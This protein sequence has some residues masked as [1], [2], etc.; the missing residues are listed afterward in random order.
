MKNNKQKLICAFLLQKFF[1]YVC[2]CMLFKRSSITD[3]HTNRDMAVKKITLKSWT[4]RIPK[5]M[6][7]VQQMRT[8]LPMGFKEDN[9]VCTTSFRPGARFITLEFNHFS[10][11]FAVSIVSNTDNKPIYSLNIVVKF[12]EVRF[13]KGYQSPTGLYFSQRLEISLYKNL[14]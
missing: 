11:S 8:M 9:R 12:F 10:V 6:K 1:Q 4:P 2:N 3:S 13:S 5:M 14:K 7:K